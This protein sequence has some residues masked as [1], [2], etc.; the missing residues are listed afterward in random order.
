MKGIY[1]LQ[2]GL[3]WYCRTPYDW[4]CAASLVL[5]YF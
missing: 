1:G 4:I 3:T 2:G 5:V